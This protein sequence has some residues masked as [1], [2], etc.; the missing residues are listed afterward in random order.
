MLLLRWD[1]FLLSLP[2]FPF[3]LPVFVLALAAMWRDQRSDPAEN[4][5]AISIHPWGKKEK[6][7]QPK[8]ALQSSNRE[9][10]LGPRWI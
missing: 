10:T 3:P 9:S 5:F 7:L 6:S 8:C 4:Q 2:D 1:T